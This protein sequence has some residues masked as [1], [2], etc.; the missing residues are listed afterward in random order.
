MQIDLTVTKMYLLLQL[1]ASL[2]I[3]A[4]TTT[5]TRRGIVRGKVH[6]DS[7]DEIFY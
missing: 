7:N 1:A 3:M 5:L 6:A 4:L 2:T